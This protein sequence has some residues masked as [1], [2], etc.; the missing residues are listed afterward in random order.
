MWYTSGEIAREITVQLPQVREWA[1]EG[2]YRSRLMSFLRGNSDVFEK[3]AVASFL[4]EHTRRASGSCGTLFV[5]G[6]LR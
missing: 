6:D 1:K 2:P 5:L 4:Q 3:L